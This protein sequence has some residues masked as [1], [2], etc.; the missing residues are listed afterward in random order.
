M[1]QPTSIPISA[2]ELGSDVEAAVLAVLRS[3]HLAQGT[4]IARFEE[5]GAAMAQTAHAV[6]V[7][8]GTVAL[9]AALE[10]SGIG[11]GDEVITTPSTF[12]ATL[13]AILRSG[14]TAR[15]VDITDDF[16]IDPAAVAAAINPKT[17]AIMP[18]HLYGLIAD[19]AAIGATADEHGLTVVEDA[20]QAHGSTQHGRAAGGFGI[21]SFSFYATKNVTSAEGGLLTTNDD[22]I[23][24][25]L[26]VL[27]NQGQRGRYDYVTIGTNLRLTD[28]AAAIAIPQMERLS[29]IIERRNH[30]A[31]RLTELL[32]GCAVTTPSIPPGRTHVWHQYTVLLPEGADRDATI[33]GL[34]QRGI[35]CGAYYPK[36]VWDYPPFR[37]HDRVIQGDTPRAAA[38][39]LRSLSLPV[40]PALTESEL[41]RIAGAVV[42][43]VG[44]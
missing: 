7:A 11:P 17:R 5:L 8:N 19:M 18:V 27:R 13:N 41:E 32:A 15:F 20:A 33:A 23:A 36:L 10:V 6:A 42:D 37:D 3:G 26:R 38:L 1:T 12:V 39:V 44:H 24:D 22:D 21:G 4:A 29:S 30:N 25:K 28:V 16:T 9:E 2:P 35:G 34:T 43:V 14:A 31:A 40:R